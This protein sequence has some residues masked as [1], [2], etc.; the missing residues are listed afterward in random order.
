MPTL[1]SSLR[2]G[3]NSE[4]ALPTVSERLFRRR[5]FEAYPA[6]R[7]KDGIRRGRDLF[8]EIKLRGYTVSLRSRSSLPTGGAPAGQQCRCSVAGAQTCLCMNAT[9]ILI[10]RRAT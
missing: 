10:Q 4:V 5:I 3:G 1:S 7:W 9:R 2:S 6:Q 8:H